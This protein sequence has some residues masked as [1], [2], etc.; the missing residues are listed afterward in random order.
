MSSAR[1]TGA[2][3]RESGEW[4]PKLLTCVWLLALFQRYM[5]AYARQGRHASARFS[6][7]RGPLRDPLLEPKLK[8]PQGR[9]FRCY[10][11]DWRE[12]RRR[13]QL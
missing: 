1:G 5:V 3:S 4:R 12:V 6:S 10:T 13:C 2:D 9:V 7:S 11:R 8:T